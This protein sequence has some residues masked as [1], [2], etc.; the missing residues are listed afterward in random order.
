MQ[1]KQ[2]RIKYNVLDVNHKNNKLLLIC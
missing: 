1:T 2:S